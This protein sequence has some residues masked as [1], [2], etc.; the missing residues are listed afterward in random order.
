MSVPSGDSLPQ[1]PWRV[2]V[3]CIVAGFAVGLAATVVLTLAVVLFDTATAA[4]A[5]QG[6][7]TVTAQVD[8]LAS[9]N[10]GP[11]LRR[12]DLRSSAAGEGTP[13]ARRALG[14][15]QAGSTAVPPAGGAR[16]LDL[17]LAW[18]LLLS[19][20]AAVLVLGGRRR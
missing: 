15:H 9:P 1:A 4:P 3:E 6:A 18:V 19:G 7:G 14:M 10:A 11:G 13:H 20:I 16:G 17:A 8:F 12:P 2:L 5:P